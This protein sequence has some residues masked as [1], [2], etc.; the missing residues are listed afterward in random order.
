MKTYPIVIIGAGA[1]GLMA[2]LR[3]AEVAAGK[4]QIHLLEKNA[5]LGRKL[6]LTGKGRCNLANANGLNDYVEKFGQNGVFLRSIFHRFFT[7]DLARFFEQ[8][9]LFLKTERQ[10]RIFPQSDSAA[11]VLDVFEKKLRVLGVHFEFSSAVRQIKSINGRV[12]SLFLENGEELA[13]GQV[14]L[15]SGGASYPQTGSTGDGFAMAQGLGHRIIKIGPG[16]VPLETEELFVKELSGLTLKNVRVIFKGRGSEIESEVGEMLLTHFGVSG[17]LILDLS[18]RVSGLLKKGPVS[19]F[20]DLKPGLT[21]EEL[22]QKLRQ[23]F[24]NFG[25]GL[26]KNYCAG[27]LPARLGPFVLAAAGVEAQQKCHQVSAAGRRK[28]V[29]V[30][31]GFRLTISKTRALSEGMITC[32]GVCL[33]EV[34]PRTLESRKIK[35]LFFC[36]E[37]LDLDAPSGGYNLMEAFSTGYVAGESAAKMFQEKER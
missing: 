26:L 12:K 14:V 5:S 3:A 29:E 7:E 34:D 8:E 9:G 13:V 11:E 16:L 37:V 32:G 17:P 10:G 22:D 30:L 31:K 23:E 19:L 2:A 20:I 27:I 6:L 1:S 33:K 28:I 25:S 21:Q 36:G 35:G 15:A 18:A 24:Q 4:V